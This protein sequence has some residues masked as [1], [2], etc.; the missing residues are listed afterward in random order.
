VTNLGTHVGVVPRGDGVGFPNAPA[1]SG[2]PPAADYADSTDEFLAPSS[3]NE[4]R[5]L[6]HRG[7]SRHRTQID[8]LVSAPRVASRIAEAVSFPPTAARSGPEMLC[9]RRCVRF[10]PVAAARNIRIE[11]GEGAACELSVLAEAEYLSACP[12]RCE[13]RGVMVDGTR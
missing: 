11:A 4:Q 9:Q 8:S 5:R 2:L 12:W 7:R 13:L 1:H 6:G 3:A 10:L